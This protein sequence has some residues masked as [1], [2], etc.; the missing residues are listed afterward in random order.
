MARGES[1]FRQWRLLKALQ[2]HWSGISS[3]ELAGRL[4]CTKRTILRDLD[5]LQQAG[6]PINFE[7]REFGRKFWKLTQGFIE[8]EKLALSITEM[9]SLFLSQRLLAPLAG[10]Q[11]GD[12]LATALQKIKSLLPKQ[13]LSYFD[14][15]DKSILVKGLVSHDYSGQDKQ[16]SILND[17]IVNERV[18]KISYRSASKKRDLTTNFHPY[19]IVLFGATLYTIGV[20]EEYGEV[21]T[22]K[23]SRIAG[24]QRTDKTFERPLNFSLAAHTHGSFG[25]FGPGKYQTIRIRF[26]GW[27]AT[28]LRE[29]QWHHSQKI[30][31][32]TS[33]QL[34]AEF[35][36]SSTVEFKRWLLGFGRHAVVLKP[37]KLVKEIAK[38]LMEAYGKYH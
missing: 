18:V 30:I 26:T 23:V 31:K 9:L 25:I 8:S 19:G 13:A 15:L 1:L 11:F 14:D 34:T 20:L 29:Q 37:K 22:L 5:I 36:L 7:Q 21:R 35:E 16:I 12:G 38:E 24:L 33:K 3:D 17:A 27:A 32:D 28:N 2:A 4:E 10:T 6:F